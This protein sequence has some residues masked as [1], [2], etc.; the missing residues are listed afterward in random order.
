MVN[1]QLGT[2]LLGFCSVFTLKN[3]VQSSSEDVGNELLQPPVV[4]SY[5]IL[6]TDLVKI[7]YIDTDFL[8]HALSV[9]KT[10]ESTKGPPIKPFCIDCV[11]GCVLVL[12][13]KF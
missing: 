3:I 6:G 1:I 8:A 4:P 13:D 9:F 12:F 11:L 7:R 2:I 10:V 5:S